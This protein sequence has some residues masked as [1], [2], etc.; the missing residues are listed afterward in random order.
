M[1]KIQ[2]SFSKVKKRL[3]GKKPKPDGT[4]ANT[5]VEGVDSSGS[6]LRPE[7]HVVAGG[8]HDG[9]QSG[10]SAVGHQAGS[11]D[12]SPQPE[13][14]L[15][16]GNDGGGQRE[17]A[18]VDGRE[19]SQIYSHPDPDVGVAVGSG[20]SQVEGEQVHPTPSVPSIPPSGKPDS[21]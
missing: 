16:G 11:E 2:N 18:G 20:P 8:G 6:F 15:A 13:P 4:G 10:T 7:P 21:T 14:M 17:K 1:D 19:V 12:R 5:P 9:E 3:R